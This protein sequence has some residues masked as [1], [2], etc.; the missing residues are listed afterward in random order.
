MFVPEN[1]IPFKK[2]TRTEAYLKHSKHRSFHQPHS[3]NLNSLYSQ[4]IALRRSVSS[5]STSSED[6]TRYISRDPTCVLHVNETGKNILLSTKIE[7]T[8]ASSAAGNS[9]AERRDTQA[10]FNLTGHRRNAS[11]SG[12]VT[13]N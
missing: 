9:D 10:T 3:S 5:A 2:I 6:E 8:S 13:Y 1:N 12:Y 11:E 4:R 7:E